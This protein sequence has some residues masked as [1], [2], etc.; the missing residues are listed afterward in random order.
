[1]EENCLST[2]LAFDCE[3]VY[4]RE[5]YAMKKVRRVTGKQTRRRFNFLGAVFS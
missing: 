5:E 3:H 4:A 1:M 2:T